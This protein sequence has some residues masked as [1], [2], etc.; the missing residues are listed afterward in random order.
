M[1]APNPT[2]MW[3]NAVS[4]RDHFA[5]HAMEAWISCDPKINGQEM[6]NKQEHANAVAAAAYLYADAML[7]QREKREAK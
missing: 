5:T 3:N 1:N 2:A 4:L 7:E 6:T